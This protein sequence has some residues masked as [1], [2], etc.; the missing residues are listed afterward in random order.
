MK[1]LFS[2]IENPHLTIN[3]NTYVLS[4][5]KNEAD[6]LNRK[7]LVLNSFQKRKINDRKKSTLLI[8]N[9]STKR[10]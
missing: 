2:L 9:T 3:I 4:G 1:K 5:N 10:R 8:R 7:T 6:K